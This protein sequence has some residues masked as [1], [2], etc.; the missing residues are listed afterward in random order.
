MKLFDSHC[1]L[2]F[3]EFD[4]DR[5]EVL[6]RMQ[7][8]GVGAVLI[9]TDL[10]TSRG[11]IE[12]AEQH[13]FLWAAVGLHPNDNRDEIFDVAA[14]TELARHPKVVAIGECGLDYFRS[15]ASDEERAAQK[16]RFLAQAMLA[17][18]AD[19]A[20]V[21]H[22]RNPLRLAE[23]EASAHSDMLL[24]LRDLRAQY[25]SLRVVIHFFTGTAEL[26]TQ[27]LDLGCYLS[28]PGPITYTDMYDAS[29]EITLL[30]RMLIETDAPFAAPVPNRGRRNE[31]PYVDHV[32]GKIAVV[33]GIDIEQVRAATLKNARKVFKLTT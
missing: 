3:P 2:H 30:D 4:A 19:K 33:K 18:S 24:L 21:I 14:F 15:G 20:L 29:I 10:A 16:E 6:A 9:G 26:A 5:S 1:H 22:C 31:P 11:A 32:A 8:A 12:L 13:D 7:E 28:F 27:Y 17:A 23:G 25:P